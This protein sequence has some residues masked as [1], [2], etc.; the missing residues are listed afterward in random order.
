MQ[1]NGMATELSISSVAPGGFSVI[2]MLGGPGSGKGTQCKLLAQAFNL[3]HISIG[4]IMRQE[5]NRAG[6]EYASIIEQNMR[7]GTVAPKEVTIPVL[8]SHMLEALQQGT[9]LFVLDGFPRSLEQA[10]FF[11]EVVA[12]IELVIVLEC[13]DATLVDRLLPRERFD[14]NLENI[15]KRL[16]TFHETTS[17]VVDLYRGRGK[18]KAVNAADAVETVHQQLVEVLKFK[19]PKS[20]DTI[21]G[22]VSEQV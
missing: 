21:G 19:E 16:R 9:D 6:S 20:Q 14:D 17:K 4:D 11:E 2:G 13:P 5:M 8:K 3:N 1:L 7:A 18:V 10:L 12:P 15:R 22:P